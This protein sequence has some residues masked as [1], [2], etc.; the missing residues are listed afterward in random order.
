M[1]KILL[2]TAA[3]VA[4]AGAAAAEVNVSGSAKLGYNSDSA[5]SPTTNTFYSELKLKL[6]FS[7]ELNN[8][9]TASAS[10]DFKLGTDGA[11]ATVTSPADWK[12]EISNDQY[13]L[14]YGKVNNAAHKTFKGP[15]GMDTGFDEVDDNEDNLLLTAKFGTV[16]AAASVGVNG[17]TVQDDVNVAVKAELGMATV[18]A[19]LQQAEATDVGGANVKASALGVSAE[20]GGATVKVGFAN[21]DGNNNYGIE[22]GYPLGPVAATV[23][24]ASNNDVPKY[25]LKA[26]YADGPISVT[27]KYEDTDGTATKTSLEGTYAV[28]DDLKVGAG[29]VDGEGTYLGVK[30][31]LGG[32]ASLL[33]SFAD[34]ESAGADEIG[35]AYDGDFKL[36]DGLTVELGLSF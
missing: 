8:G 5:P 28:N 30:Y 23:Y 1:K 4:F 16:E 3:V 29:F 19:A 20:L 15:S 14:S 21:Q 22:V 12:V 10:S 27:A 2:S 9:W 35:D 32:G 18:Y 6:G 36:N 24:Y 31:A 13:S 33:V 7:Q 26:V 11:G 17:N 25:G 34:A